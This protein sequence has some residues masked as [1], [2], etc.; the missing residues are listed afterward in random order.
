MPRSTV[1]LPDGVGAEDAD[2]EFSDDDEETDQ[3]PECKRRKTD[4]E[5][6]SEDDSSSFDLEASEAHLRQAWVLF[7]VLLIA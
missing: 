3:Q 2:D 7:I 6:T 5:V 4:K 1:T